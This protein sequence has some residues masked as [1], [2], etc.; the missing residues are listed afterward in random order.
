[1]LSA[2]EGMEQVAPT[3]TPYVLPAAVVILLALFAFQPL[4][5]ATIGRAFGPIMLF[6]FL[7][8]AALGLYGIAQHPS[9]FIAVNPL[10]GYKYLLGGGLQGFLVLGGVFL[11]VTGAEALYADM[12]HFGSTP[13]SRAWNFCLLYTSPS[14]RDRQK[15]RMP[16][17]A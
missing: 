15:S 8:M 10:Y 2:L 13:I 16:S 7:V 11:C 5:T 3:L 12:G 9:V 17:S 1:M 6:W 4:G 14:P